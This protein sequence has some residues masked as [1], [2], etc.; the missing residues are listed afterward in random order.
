MAKSGYSFLY[1]GAALK[2]KGCLYIKVCHEGLVA[3][4]TYKT[5]NVREKTVDCKLL[6]DKAILVEVNLSEV[7][8][9]V[10]PKN[11]IE[12]AQIIFESQ[13]C[14]EIECERFKDCVPDGLPIGESCKVIRIHANFL[15]P[16]RKVELVKVSLLPRRA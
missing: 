3:G 15:C 14:G 12:G 6:C 13:P 1:E 5:I 11:A 9:V 4:R 2:C 7:D 8:A 10:N 16:I